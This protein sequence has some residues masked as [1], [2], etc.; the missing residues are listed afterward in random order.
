MMWEVYGGH[1]S[2]A[3]LGVNPVSMSCA[4]R[5]A[6]RTEQELKDGTNMPCTWTPHQIDR[7]L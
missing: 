2:A 6:G 3:L 1:C 7:C 5:D 4:F